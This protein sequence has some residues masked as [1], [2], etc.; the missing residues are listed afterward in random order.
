MYTLLTILLFNIIKYY[1]PKQNT[2]NTPRKRIFFNKTI[3]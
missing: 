2:T 1:Q 3:G